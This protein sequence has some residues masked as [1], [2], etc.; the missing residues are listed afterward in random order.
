M[1][2]KKSGWIAIIAQGLGDHLSQS[3]ARLNFPKDDQAA[4]G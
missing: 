4:I 1:S 2:P 3:E